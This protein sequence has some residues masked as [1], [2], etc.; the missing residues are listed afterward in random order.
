MATQPQTQTQQNAN[1]LVQLI[2]QQLL[3]QLTQAAPGLLEGLFNSLFHKNK[4]APVAPITGGVRL[5]DDDHIP[6]P[7]P[8]VVA[9]PK[10]ARAVIYIQKAQYNATLFPDMYTPENPQGLYADP[11]GMVARG[12]AFNRQSKIWIDITA[13]DAAG[14]EMPA[15][16]NHFAFLAE[17]RITA[18]DGSVLVMQGHGQNPDGSPIS[19]GEPGTPGSYTPSESNQVGAGITSWINSIGCNLQIKTFAEGTFGVAG[20]QAGVSASGF[21]FRVS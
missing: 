8:V 20:S 21:S 12:E 11:M 10:P 6:A 2:V 3:Q 14:N 17:H 18:P 13:F 19:T 1:P 5:P 15:G 7:T 9:A 16:P 4:P